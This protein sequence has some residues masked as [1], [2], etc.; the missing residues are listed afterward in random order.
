MS[1]PAGRVCERSGALLISLGGLDVAL[2]PSGALWLAE[3]AI[4]VVGDLHLE[5][6]SAY[7]ARGQ[8]LPPFDTADTLARLEAE[9]AALS[10]AVLVLLGDSFH[11]RRALDRMSSV[12]ADRIAGLGRGRSLIWIVGNHD[13]EGLG[14]A[15]RDGL[16][17]LPGDLA[18]ELSAGAL[19][20]RHEPVEG[21]GPGEVCGHLHPCAK[22]VRAGRS[23]RR[24]AFITDGLRLIL[25][26]F[27]AYAGGLNVR[28]AAFAGLFERAPTVGALGER[29]VYA[30]PFGALSRD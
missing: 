19:T 5:K 10:P 4:L 28:D 6:G 8:L 18:A 15:F 29:R 2:R 14:Q 24:R 21:S 17:R 23:V 12:D 3:M 30:L 9:V 26:A 22:V 1:G 11:D 25:P 16:K 13:E 7:A 20:F 27:G